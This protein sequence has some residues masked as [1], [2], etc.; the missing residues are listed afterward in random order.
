MAFDLEHW[1]LIQQ[2]LAHDNSLASLLGHRREQN[3]SSLD[4]EAVDQAFPREHDAGES[5]S[6]HL[7][8][9]CV[10]L[11]QGLNHNLGTD[12]VEAQS[13][14]DGLG[15]SSELGVLRADVDRVGVSG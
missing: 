11:G 12:P 2:G 8:L 5:G 3:C 13:V 1:S 9:A 7:E 15:Q 4:P 6:D 10:V 14:E